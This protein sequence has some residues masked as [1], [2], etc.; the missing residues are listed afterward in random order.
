MVGARAGARELR[1][2]VA[3]EASGAG[4]D[5]VFSART[6]PAA[7]RLAA[8]ERTRL[9]AVPIEADAAIGFAS[10][11]HARCDDALA[12]AARERERQ[13]VAECV[14]R[15]GGGAAAARRSAVTLAPRPAPALVA[16][17]RRRSEAT[18]AVAAAAD[19]G[20]GV[21]QRSGDGALRLRVPRAA[22]K[23]SAAL[24]RGV[25]LPCVP[26]VRA[27]HCGPRRKRKRRGGIRFEARL[28]R[29][30]TDTRGAVASA[31]AGLTCAL[32]LRGGAVPV[33][34]AVV[35]AHRCLASRSDP[36]HGAGA[37]GARP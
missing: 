12:T 27:L 30:A 24:K 22:Q 19:H 4:A 18:R 37:H 2:A 36:T 13:R 20:G 7:V 9:A 31:P 35:R 16:L 25:E 23:P 26:T 1:A 29:D 8:L 14:A 11:V 34:A 15:R 6:V 5:S 10:A 21:E 3:R 17:A 33:R 28:R 32:A